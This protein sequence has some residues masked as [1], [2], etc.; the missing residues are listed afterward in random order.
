M[1]LV[2][3]LCQIDAKPTKF[4]LLIAR[5]STLEVHL[6]IRKEPSS[7]SSFIHP[8]P[9]LDSKV[10]GCKWIFHERLGCDIRE[11]DVAQANLSASNV[12]FSNYTCRNGLHVAV[13]NVVRAI[14]NGESNRKIRIQ[15][16]W[17]R[18]FMG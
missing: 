9:P 11:I 8:G 14:R 17:V 4:Y 16:I 6:T 13:N 15:I 1:D 5:N 10:V 18:C 3:N 7:I 2:F 12:D